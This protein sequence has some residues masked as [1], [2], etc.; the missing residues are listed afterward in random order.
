MEQLALNM[1]QEYW[2]QISDW[3]TFNGQ[4][5]F[6]VFLHTDKIIFK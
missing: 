1:S 5:Q 3:N 6:F 4:K 2:S